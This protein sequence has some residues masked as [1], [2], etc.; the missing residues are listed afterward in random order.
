MNKKKNS[1]ESHWQLPLVPHFDPPLQ[2][3]IEIQI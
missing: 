3:F 1:L 2:K